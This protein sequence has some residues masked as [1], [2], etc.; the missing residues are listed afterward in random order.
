M[1]RKSII[2]PLL[3]IISSCGGGGSDSPEV[4]PGGSAPPP[5]PPLVKTTDLVTNSN[6][7]FGSNYTLTVVL[8]V[9]PD[10]TGDYFINICTSY[11]PDNSVIKDYASCKVRSYLRNNSQTFE[12]VLS[13][14]ERDLIAQVWP[15]QQGAS[16]NSYYFK[17]SGVSDRWELNY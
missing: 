4:T 8:P 17:S 3:L 2:L 13:E 7:D 10:N 5:P 16:A 12:L 14:S 11:D 9:K 15:I 6:F 1:K